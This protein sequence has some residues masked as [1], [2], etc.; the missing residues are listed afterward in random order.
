MLNECAAVLSGSATGAR[1]LPMLSV[2][3]FGQHAAR[4]HSC[5]WDL[6]VIKMLLYL[7][8]GLGDEPLHRSHAFVT[9]VRIG[10]KALGEI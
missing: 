9:L 2:G 8:I 1:G 6:M 5:S 10:Y 7:L 4:R 3:A